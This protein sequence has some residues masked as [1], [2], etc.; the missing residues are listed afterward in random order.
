MSFDSCLS[1]QGRIKEIFLL[2][3]TP[4]MR[5]TKLIELGSELP[6]F[7]LD[8]KRPENLVSGCQSEMHIKTLQVDGKLFFYAHSDSLVSKGLAYLVVSVYSGEPAPTIF[9]CPPTYLDEIG[10]SKALSP[11][12]SNGLASLLLRM[13]QEAIKSV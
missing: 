8:W 1:K 7:D 12:R 2:C 6:H 4:E 9:S 3:S 10:I 13:K 5:Y 11:G